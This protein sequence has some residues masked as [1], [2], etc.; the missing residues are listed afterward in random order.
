MFAFHRSD[1]GLNP[2]RG[3][4]FDNDKHYTLP[5]VNPTCH[6][7]EVGKWVPVKLLGSNCGN[8]RE[9]SG[10]LPHFVEAIEKGAYGSLSTSVIQFDIFDG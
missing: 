5:C 8:T 7:S 6:P 10:A 1:R 9:R 3:S 4:E 2:G